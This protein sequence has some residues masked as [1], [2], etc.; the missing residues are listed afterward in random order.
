MVVVEDLHWA[1]AATEEFLATIVED[2]PAGRIL[3]LFTYRPGYANPFGERTFH[4][5]LVLTP[6]PADA[7][8]AMARAALDLCGAPVG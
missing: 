4:T 2:A 5:R 7:T 1:D 6:L 8:A 3:F